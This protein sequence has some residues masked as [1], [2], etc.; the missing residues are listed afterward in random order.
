MC[1]VWIPEQATVMCVVW[2]PEQATVMCVV[3]IP[4]QAT[5]ISLRALTGWFYE[6][7]LIECTKVV[8]YD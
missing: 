4:D 2:I 5:V 3:W 8:T 7:V 1:V 6:S